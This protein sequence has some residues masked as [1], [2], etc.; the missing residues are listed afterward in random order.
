MKPIGVMSEQPKC[1]AI[2]LSQL[3][4]HGLVGKQQQQ[5]LGSSKETDC[6]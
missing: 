5:A 4:P 2:G 1:G 3:Q 6:L